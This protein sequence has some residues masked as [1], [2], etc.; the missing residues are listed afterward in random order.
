MAKSKGVTVLRSPKYHNELNP[1]EP[2]WPI[3]KN[4]IVKNLA[5][6]TS[7]SSAKLIVNNALI[8]V[9]PHK[10]KKYIDQVKSAELEMHKLDQNIDDITDS[11]LKFL[12]KPRF[13]GDEISSGSSES[14]PD[15]V[16]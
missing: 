10:W 15:V 14:E 3:I 9:S 12:R 5:L 1:F 2:V 8:E 7:L 11:Y 6:P 13:P 4:H 16:F